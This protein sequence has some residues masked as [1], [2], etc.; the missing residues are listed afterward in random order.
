VEGGRTGRSLTEVAR[1][2]VEISN[3][4]PCQFCSL[5]GDKMNCDWH[6]CPTEDKSFHDFPRL[7][8]ELQGIETR[9]GTSRIPRPPVTE[10]LVKLDSY[11]VAKTHSADAILVLLIQSPVSRRNKFLPIIPH[12]PAMCSLSINMTT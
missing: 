11:Q 3:Q 4:P 6:F 10:I 5:N 2:F 12:I 7:Q 9:Q 8:G 1:R